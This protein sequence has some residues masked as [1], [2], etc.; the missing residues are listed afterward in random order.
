[1]CSEL[2]SSYVDA[3][4]DTHA[5][6][7]TQKSL[8]RIPCISSPYANFTVVGVCNEWQCRIN[9]C[10]RAS[11]SWLTDGIQTHM[12]LGNVKIRLDWTK[13]PRLI[14]Q[15]HPQLFQSCPEVLR[16]E[17]E[18]K[19]TGTEQKKTTRV[20]TLKRRSQHL[21]ITDLMPFFIFKQLLIKYADIKKACKGHWCTVKRKCVCVCLC[22]VW[23]SG[24]DV[25]HSSRQP[26]WWSPAGSISGLS[27]W[28]VRAVLT[29]TLL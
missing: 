10:H 18:K 1:M 12:E 7:D 8:S 4:A 3:Q 16:R 6:I 9:E 24:C 11:L 20:K 26:S 13:F 27:V 28:N 2:Y 21:S 22:V 29:S 14:F 15:K 19:G 17:R 25:F 23:V 5:H